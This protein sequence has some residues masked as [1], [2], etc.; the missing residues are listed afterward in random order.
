MT[1]IGIVGF[2]LIMANFAFFAKIFT[3]QF[4]LKFKIS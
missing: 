1:D 3:A 2:I 4:S